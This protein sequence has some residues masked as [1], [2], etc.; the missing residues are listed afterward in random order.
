MKRM[1][2]KP[3]LKQNASVH[4]QR[5]DHG[6]WGRRADV[7]RRSRRWREALS[8]HNRALRLN[9]LDSTS[10]DAFLNDLAGK[11]ECLSRLGRVAQSRRCAAEARRLRRS[12]RQRRR[13]ASDWPDDWERFFRA[14]RP[15]FKGRR[16]E[17]QIFDA[18]IDYIWRRQG[19]SG[20]LRGTLKHLDPGNRRLRSLVR[21]VRRISP[22]GKQALVRDRA[23]FENATLVPSMGGEI[24]SIRSSTRQAL[25]CFIR[26]YGGPGVV[27]LYE[28]A[29]ELYES[30]PALSGT[31]V[32]GKRMTAAE[33]MRFESGAARG[34][35]ERAVRRSQELH[36]AM[37]L[38][39]AEGGR[40][41]LWPSE[42][43]ARAESELSIRFP[44]FG[45]EPIARA[46]ARAREG[47]R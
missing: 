6:D 17:D 43:V 3:Q 16:T 41:D 7:L 47:A 1:G 20:P 35:C 2:A 22:P 8:A 45:P 23:L 21:L 33:R 11:F 31:K 19:L 42:R 4:R 37:L 38:L 13:R 5:R 40:P 10:R 28:R 12:W 46:F 39:F 26:K 44:E 14:D 34:R 32:R 29:L 15:R 36:Q 9:P 30:P 24:E 25:E 27:D 18:I